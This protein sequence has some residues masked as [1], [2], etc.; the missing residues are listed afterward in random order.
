[1]PRGRLNSVVGQHSPC[2]TQAREMLKHYIYR[3]DHDLGFAPNPDYG[4][5]SLCG[6]KISTIEAWAS[7]GS[8]VVGIGGKGTGKSNKLI[9]AMQVEEVLPF[10]IF[11]ARYKRKSAYLRG[12]QIDPAAKVLLSRKFYYFG[13]KAVELPEELQYIIIRGRGCKRIE[14]EDA[15]R[16]KKYLARRYSYG[17]QGSPNNAPQQ[18]AARC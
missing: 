10:A 9:Y 5:C 13:D 8:W 15:I 6:C 7:E 3:I 2:D 18:E 17:K 12:R 11:Q 14:N 16:L 1:M 4:I